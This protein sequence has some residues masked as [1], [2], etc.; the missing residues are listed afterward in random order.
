M[1]KKRREKKTIKILW[2]S[3]LSYRDTDKKRHTHTHRHTEKCL[4]WSH[5]QFYAAWIMHAPSEWKQT[6]K[7]FFLISITIYTPPTQWNNMVFFALRHMSWEINAKVTKKEEE[8]WNAKLMERKKTIMTASCQI[9][10][11]DN[12]K[13]YNNKNKIAT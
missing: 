11:C 4:L 2:V 5:N 7:Y 12:L 3:A 6:A 13:Y 9:D 1:D 10:G 8:E